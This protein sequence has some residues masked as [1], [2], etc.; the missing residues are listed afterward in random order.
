MVLN[1]H[2]DYQSNGHE[3]PNLAK[4]QSI[5]SNSKANKNN[6]SLQAKVGHSNEKTQS[7]EQL[8]EVLREKS[9][10]RPSNQTNNNFSSTT[11]NLHN[12]LLS[13]GKQKKNPQS[14]I[15]NK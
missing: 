11:P 2:F 4:I 10:N 5:L 14:N 6:Q 8:R 3:S 9:N 15:S 13:T 7:P 12:N 1:N